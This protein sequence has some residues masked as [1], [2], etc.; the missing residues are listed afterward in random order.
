MKRF[1]LLLSCS[2]ALLLSFPSSSFA[3]RCATKGSVLCVAR[4]DCPDDS[5]YGGYCCD[6]LS[7]C[8]DTT[9][10][11]PLSAPNPLCGTNDLGVRTA[12]G[13]L[14]AGDPKQL[15]SQ[16]LGWGVGIGGGIAFL[17]IIFAGFQMATASGDPKRVK[18]AQEL[19]TSALAGLILIVLSV[20]L[21]NFIGVSILGINLLGFNLNL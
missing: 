12:I 2:L 1:L 17:M 20:V 6:D 8:Y 19:L 18:A 15:V 9:T 11:P 3:V 21:L 10:T 4:I 5:H 7:Q 16:L 13:C 14:M